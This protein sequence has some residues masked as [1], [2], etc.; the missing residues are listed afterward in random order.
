MFKA[1]DAAKTLCEENYGLHLMIVYPDL[2]TLRKFYCTY[3]KKE[4]EDYNGLVVIAS[5]YETIESVRA[6]LLQPPYS[7]DV[8]RYEG[9]RSLSIVDAKWLYSSYEWV[10]EFVNNIAKGANGLGKEGVT[11]MGD[12]GLFYSR[13]HHNEVMNYEISHLPKRF[14]VDRKGFCLYAEKDISNLSADQSLRLFEQHG[15]VIEIKPE[16][17]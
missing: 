14:S 2:N 12:M 11:V 15:M 8:S 6:N 10:S 5:Y 17:S 4:I 3:A 13:G 7:L 16:K 1:E 9:D